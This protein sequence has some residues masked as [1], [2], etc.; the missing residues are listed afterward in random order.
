MKALRSIIFSFSFIFLFTQLLF[1]Q[2][3]KI[4]V[5]PFD[6]LNK[7]KNSELETLTVGISETL[8][9]A[10]STVDKFIIIDSDR[11]KRHILN[12]ATFKQTIGVDGEKDLEKLRELTK[13]KLDGDYIIYGSFNKIGGQIQLTAKFMEVSTGKVLK[14][15][16][17]HG[18]YPDDI[19]MLQEELAKELMNRITGSTGISKS[20]I[21]IERKNSIEEYTKSTENY[22]AYQ[23]YI[24][25]RMEQIQYDV[26]NYPLAIEYYEKALKYDPK[27]AL[28]WAG[29]SEVNALWGYQIKYANGNWQPYLKIAVEQGKKAVEYGRN[30]YQT[31]RALSMAYLNNSEFD[32]AQKSID[33]AYRLNR[34]DA[35]TL[36]IMAQ[37]KN[38]G[39]KEMA[40][41]GTESNRYIME[42]LRINPELIIARWALAHSYSTI[43]DKENALNQYMEILKVNPKHAPALHGIALIYYGKG[44]YYNSEYYAL[45]TVEADPKTAQ[46]HYTLA[47]AYYQQGYSNPS[48]WD[49]AEIS[50]KNALNLNP[51]YIDAIVTLGQTYYN[52]RNYNAAIAEFKKALAKDPKNDRAYNEMAISYYAL[53]DYKSAERYSLLAVQYNPTNAINN[54]NLGLAYYMQKNWEK[55]IAAFEKAVTYDPNY[56]NAWFNLANCYWFTN[57]FDRAYEYYNKVLELNPNNSEAQR[58]RDDSYQKMGR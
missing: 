55:A 3:Y 7:E 37:L 25:G 44:D 26:K 47:L 58:W 22:T 24:K 50:F 8:S 10:L 29:L 23:Y 57:R 21:P 15:A 9:G 14:G 56:E 54:Y 53:G 1:S 19:F 16:N 39:Y 28:A 20:S 35:E 45:K 32:L 2:S 42:C 33:E 49:S 34:Q 36:E 41:A 52:K 30:L 51:E 48:K 12:N 31:H 11:V 27:Y 18:K 5:M 38:Y 6:K 13:D 40:K 4:V 17:V 43:G 46:H